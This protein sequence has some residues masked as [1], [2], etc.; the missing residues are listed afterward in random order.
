MG[1]ARAVLLLSALVFGGFGLAFTVRPVALARLVDIRLESPTARIEF[2]A[3]YGGFELG[4]AA[5]LLICAREPAWVRPGLV[6]SGS[7][8]AGFAA[9]R[10]LGLATQPGGWPLLSVLFAA[11]AA[12]SA[13]SF[14]AAGRAVHPRRGGAGEGT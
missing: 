1:I 8:L 6:L 13:L 3:M 7:A 10:L 4:V 11:E 14:W 12:G 9:V 2:A 5:F